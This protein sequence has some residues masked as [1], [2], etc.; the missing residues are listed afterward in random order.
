MKKNKT[1]EVIK[2]VAIVL[3]NIVITLAVVPMGA[4]LSEVLYE[5]TDWS[6]CGEGSWE[7]GKYML[8]PQ[9]TWLL[10]KLKK[11]LKDTL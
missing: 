5:L 6:V 3:L 4:I 10:V 7:F 11:A 9:C 1:K 2:I 8:V